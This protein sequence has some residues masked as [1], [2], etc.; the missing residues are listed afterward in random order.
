MAIN[1]QNNVLPIDLLMDKK[2]IRPEDIARQKRIGE[3]LRRLRL[4]RG[5]KR[6]QDL[7]DKLGFSRNYIGRLESG[8][9]SFGSDAERKFAKFFQVDI[10]EF[11]K[12][13]DIKS[14]PIVEKVCT[15]LEDMSETEKRDVL[16]Y[17]EE[18]K[19][20]AGFRKRKAS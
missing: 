5:F 14:D 16:K 19:L 6:Q 12:G 17:T 10:S 7:A 9:A 4:S 3:N 15:M 13:T 11:Y 2:K 1:R 8:H 20:I 18:K